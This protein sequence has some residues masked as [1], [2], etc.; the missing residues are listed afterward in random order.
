MPLPCVVYTRRRTFSYFASK[1]TMCRQPVF[2][3]RRRE[4]LEEHLPCTLARAH[5]EA[6]NTAQ[7]RRTANHLRTATGA[8]H[9][10]VRAHGKAAQRMAKVSCTT[11]HWVHGSERGARLSGGARQRNRCC[12]PH[13]RAIFAVQ[14][15][16]SNTLPCI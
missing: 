12:R 10:K 8:A 15:R 6:R 11:T 9:V 5:G 7:G 3:A 2:L 4:C 1:G 13:C 14:R 16:T